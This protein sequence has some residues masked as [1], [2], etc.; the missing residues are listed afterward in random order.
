MLCLLLQLDWFQ[1]SILKDSVIQ[2]FWT[3]S[4]KSCQRLLKYFSRASSSLLLNSSAMT[5]WL[6]A[7]SAT[8]IPKLGGGGGELG[9]T[10]LRRNAPKQC[11]CSSL[12][13]ADRH[14]EPYV[15]FLGV[16]RLRN[17]SE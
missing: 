1:A 16:L 9:Y 6:L 5:K 11:S 7:T 2:W 4:L 17:F 14:C 12:P 8:Q 10:D 15:I 3:R 13:V